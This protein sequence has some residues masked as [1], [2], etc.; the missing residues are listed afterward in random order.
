MLKDDDVRK[1]RDPCRDLKVHLPDRASD[2]IFGPPIWLDK[3]ETSV[4]FATDV[5]AIEESVSRRMPVINVYVIST[6]VEH[7]RG[8]QY[9]FSKVPSRLFKLRSSDFWKVGLYPTIGVDRVAALRG[10]RACFGLPALVIDGGTAMTFTASD[11]DGE[12]MGGNISVGLAWRI[13][14]L[15]RSMPKFGGAPLMQLED[16]QAIINEDE[17][18]ECFSTDSKKSVL[19]CALMDIGYKCHHVVKTWL[20]E[21][22]PATDPSDDCDMEEKEEKDERNIH[23]AK[24][25]ETNHHR[26]V[27]I[28]G[29]DMDIIARL[30]EKVNGQLH[31]RIIEPEPGAMEPTSVGEYTVERFRGAIHY[32]IAQ[33][34][35]EK[36]NEQIA[37]QQG[38]GSPETESLR[39]QILGLRVAMIESEFDDF[40][41]GS[42][43]SVS[44]GRTIDDDWFLVHH[45]DGEDRNYNII[46]IFGEFIRRSVK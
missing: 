39:N 42:V 13:K 10:A 35:V 15:H 12:L 24:K 1:G 27:T 40:R 34:L 26:A 36:S 43:V 44:P 14:A 6:N 11:A 8:L 37:Q 9:L 46:Q 28:T 31:S 20:D 4:Q 21:V 16:V 29:G 45:D 41:R 7:E 18:L 19:N 17:P 33:V 2:F 5:H 3:S 38:K 32:G 25:T 22:G 30:L 23:S